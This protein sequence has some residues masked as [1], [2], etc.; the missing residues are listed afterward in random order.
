MHENSFF[1]RDVC[2]K[3]TYRSLLDRQNEMRTTAVAHHKE[4][5]SNLNDLINSYNSKSKEFKLSFKTEAKLD[6]DN[7]VIRIINYIIV[8]DSKRNLKKNRL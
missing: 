8:T 5:S 2:N 3:I 7:N 6:N 1:N 4:S